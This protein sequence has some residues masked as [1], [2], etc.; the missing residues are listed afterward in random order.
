[1]Q[2]RI[3]PRMFLLIAA[4]PLLLPLSLWLSASASFPMAGEGS[5]DPSFAV[6]EGPNGPFLLVLEEKKERLRLS[7]PGSEDVFIGLGDEVVY[8]KNRSTGVAVHAVVRSLQRD[9]TMWLKRVNGEDKVRVL[10]ID[11]ASHV[12]P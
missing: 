3:N 7:R 11:R 4:S 12:C 1:M 9:G 2:T 8:V 5:A 10:W 6:A